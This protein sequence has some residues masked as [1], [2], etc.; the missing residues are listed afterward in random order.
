MPL[1]YFW[2]CRM[3]MS[4]SYQ[5]RHQPVRAKEYVH[6]PLFKGSTKVPAQVRTRCD[7]STH[8]VITPV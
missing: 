7:N 5:T 1:V 4:I 8:G 6:G 2:Q 3:Q